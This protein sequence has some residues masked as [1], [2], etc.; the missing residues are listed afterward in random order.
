MTTTALPRLIAILALLAAAGLVLWLAAGT[1]SLFGQSTID[2]DTD[3]DGLIEISN[4]EQFNS[5][6]YDRDGRGDET[7]SGWTDHWPNRQTGASNRMGCP[8]GNCSGYELIAHNLHPRRGG[9]FPLSR[10]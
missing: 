6:R 7:W 10:E 8:S 9:G 5:I 2:Y 1:P 3:D 4:W